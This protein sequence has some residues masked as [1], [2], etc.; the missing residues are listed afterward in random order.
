MKIRFNLIKTV[1]L[2]VSALTIT[3]GSSW[4]ALALLHPFWKTTFLMR[5]YLRI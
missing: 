5:R 2:T 4:L 1:V 3:I